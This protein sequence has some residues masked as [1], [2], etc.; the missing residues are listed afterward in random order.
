M[1]PVHQAIL[2]LLADGEARPVADIADSTGKSVSY[3][4]EMLHQLQQARHIQ[5]RMQK[6]GRPPS[7]HNKRM[8]E[9]M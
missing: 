6:P 7:T 5:S 9:K 4:W 2:E 1:K 8:Y 3:T